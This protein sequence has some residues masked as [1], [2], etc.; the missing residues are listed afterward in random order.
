MLALTPQKCIIAKVKSVPMGSSRPITRLA[1]ACSRNTT[2]T[3]KV[4]SS[5][6]QRAVVRVLRVS[7]ISC[8]RS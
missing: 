5:S 1:R 2:T 7:A 6:S 3:A 4:V 8:E